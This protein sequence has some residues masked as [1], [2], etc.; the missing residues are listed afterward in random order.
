MKG[1]NTVEIY[2]K[3]CHCVRRERENQ[4]EHL[5]AFRKK[6]KRML[7]DTTW[8]YLVTFSFNG[9]EKQVYMWKWESSTSVVLT[10]QI[11]SRAIY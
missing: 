5:Y 2:H 4:H 3:V 1:G 9:I 11:I 6:Q 7:F 10:S 8:Q